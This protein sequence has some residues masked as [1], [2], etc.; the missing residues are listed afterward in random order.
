M[1]N[2]VYLLSRNKIIPMIAICSKFKY[3]VQL[4]VKFYTFREHKF[5]REI[6]YGGY[7]YLQNGEKT[8]NFN[9]QWITILHNIILNKQAF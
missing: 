1:D 9:I 8:L 4:R 7:K 2:P 3:Y 5:N 6:K